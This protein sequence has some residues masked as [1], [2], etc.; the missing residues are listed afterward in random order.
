MTAGPVIV[1][2]AVFGAVGAL[3]AFPLRLAAREVERR[4]AELRRG[5][6]RRTT[7]VVFGRTLLAKA[8]TGRTGDA[9]IVR[10]TNAE[11]EAGRALI[12]EN[13]FLRLLGLMKAPEA[14]S[15]SRQSLIDQSRLAGDD[16]DMLSLFDAFEHDGEPYSFRDLILARKY[17]GLIASGATWGAIARSV[18]RSG[19]VASL[20]AKSLNV[21]SQHGRPDAIYL[22]EGLSEL[23]GQLLFDLGS[24]E[25]DTLEEL[26][27]EAETAEEEER[28]DD[29]AT[30]YQ[31][32]LAIDPSDAIAAFNRANCLRGASR[33][34]EAAHDYA[35]AIKL[36]PGFVEAWFNLAGLMS[37]EGK[38]ASARRHLQKA[39]TLDKAYAD[40]VFN[41]ARLE[42]DAGN[43][44]EA[45][46]LWARYLELDTDSEW[47]RLARKGIQFVDLHMARTAG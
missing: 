24:P 2:G 13:G 25:D 7:H 4:H 18:H 11:R 1:P 16:L 43:F 12:S 42:F 8:A 40:P 30:L 45:R 28:H 22:D 39:I 38:V 5:V 20:T 9:E 32:C 19:P 29:A 17:A 27:A 10:R 35:R 34:A 47:A 46:R 21:G 23:D 26:F 44:P 36:D 33:V 37:D 15:L 14:S 6:T 31:R 41:L 3:A